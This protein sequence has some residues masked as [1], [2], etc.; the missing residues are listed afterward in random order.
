MA[1]VECTAAPLS[2][3]P[4]AAAG[5]ARLPR[6]AGVLAVL[7]A[8]AVVGSATLAALL[9]I[10]FSIAIVFLF[11]GLHNWLEARYLLSRMP[12]RW[13]RL[14]AYYA[15][16]I[17]GVV[18]LT[19][20]MIVL[21]GIAAAAGERGHHHAVRECEVAES[22]GLEQRTGRG[23][24]RV[25]RPVHGIPGRVS[26]E[27]AREEPLSGPVHRRWRESSSERA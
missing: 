16:G 26:R 22:T 14:R 27:A 13:G 11:A 4:A 9:P 1:T 25:G 19:A 3:R 24:T 17:G 6:A 18:G 10:G 7:M 21:P 20:G 15:A 5:E 2:M 12:P 23:R 8:A